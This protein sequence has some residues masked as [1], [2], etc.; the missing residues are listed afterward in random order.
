MAD[1]A[2]GVVSPG[3]REQEEGQENKV[4]DQ[5]MLTSIEF[6]LEKV[7]IEYSNLGFADPVA[8]GWLDSIVLDANG[9]KAIRFYI[10]E[11]PGA[12]QG[13]FSSGETCDANRVSRKVLNINT[14]K[15]APPDE[16]GIR[17]IRG[18]DWATLA[19][20]LMHPVLYASRFMQ[21]RCT[22][23][24]WISEGI[25]DAISFDVTR[26][27]LGI[28]FR[29][30]LEPET[31]SRILKIYGIRN[32]AQPLQGHILAANPAT[33][34]A[35]FK[36]D[37]TLLE[38]ANINTNYPTS[39]FW[40]YLAE[41]W[42]VKRRNPNAPFPGSRANAGVGISYVDYGYLVEMF[43]KEHPYS[44][45]PMKANPAGYAAKQ[46]WMAALDAVSEGSQTT[47]GAYSRP[48][49]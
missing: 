30:A 36:L 49:Q 32:Y 4:L 12:P 41:T 45:D 25:P 10:R 28:D 33:N 5:S 26:K 46:E 47:L 6:F 9:D 14:L 42:Y 48:W 2:L 8:A 19:H 1:Q 29:D 7:A 21:G 43:D 35:G 23:G 20:E 3:W 31:D 16:Q 39:S 34:T 22:V 40:R 13:W 15:F 37:E 11:K 17:V 24:G 38:N 27:V 44:P 18:V